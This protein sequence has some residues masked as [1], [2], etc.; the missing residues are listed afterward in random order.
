[1]RSVGEWWSM[2]HMR[3]LQLCSSAALPPGGVGCGESYRSLNLWIFPV[4][5]LGSS[6]KNTT[7]RGL[8][9]AAIFST[10]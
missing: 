2:P 1:M 10:Q 6:S 3:P 5:V 8:L 4:A 9:Y 7:Q